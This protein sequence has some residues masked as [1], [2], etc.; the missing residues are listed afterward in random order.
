MVEWPCPSAGQ[1]S[2]VT[3]QSVQFLEAHI[4]HRPSPSQSTHHS[5]TPSSNGCDFPLMPHHPSLDDKNQQALTFESSIFSRQWF[6]LICKTTSFLFSLPG[7]RLKAK[8]LT[9]WSIPF[10]EID[11]QSLFEEEFQFPRSHFWWRKL[12]S[13][14][15]LEDIAKF[16]QNEFIQDSEETPGGL[17]SACGYRHC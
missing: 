7:K 9:I 15:G 5:Q 6:L 10:T 17:S 14:L 8:F 11:Q 1:Q 12:I 4:I 13:V 2:S 3:R 16:L